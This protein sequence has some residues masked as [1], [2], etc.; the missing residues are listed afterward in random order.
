MHA[1]SRNST[2]KTYEK[3]IKRLKADLLDGILRFFYCCRHL[4]LQPGSVR[5]V[6]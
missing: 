5:L 1:S 4:V 3:Q 6:I 2:K